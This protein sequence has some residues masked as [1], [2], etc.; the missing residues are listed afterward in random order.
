MS[1]N[2]LAYRTSGSPGTVV[3]FPKLFLSFGFKNSQ[4]LPFKSM[5]HL[6]YSV[7]EENK[8]SACFSSASSSESLALNNVEHILTIHIFHSEKCNAVQNFAILQ[9][10]SAVFLECYKMESLMEIHL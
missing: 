6:L 1:F 9:K 8:L 3:S 2:S 10:Y 7:R 4:F 5:Y